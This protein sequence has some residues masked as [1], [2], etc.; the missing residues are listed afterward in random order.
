VLG[1]WRLAKRATFQIDAKG[2]IRHIDRGRDAMDPARVLQ[3][4]SLLAPPSE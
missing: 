3:A 4:V 2:V 1:F